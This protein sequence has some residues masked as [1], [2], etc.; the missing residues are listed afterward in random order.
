V[1][2]SLTELT[3]IRLSLQTRAAAL[4]AHAV[5]N[6]D[7]TAA[8]ELLRLSVECKELDVQIAAISNK[9]WKKRRPADTAQ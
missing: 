7:A 1:L 6:P 2:T 8:T 4:Q 5:A 9:I 3:K